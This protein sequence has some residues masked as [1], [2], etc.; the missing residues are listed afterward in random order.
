MLN[1]NNNNN[2]DSSTNLEST[3]FKTNDET[4]YKT[5]NNEKMS[6]IQK[7]LKRA[8]NETRK[9]WI[10]ILSTADESSSSSIESIYEK[11]LEQQISFKSLDSSSLSKYNQ[12]NDVSSSS[13]TADNSLSTKN[14]A[15]R[16]V[17]QIEKKASITE[18][19][20]D[21]APA[22]INLLTN[23]SSNLRLQVLNESNESKI[24]DKSLKIHSLATQAIKKEILTVRNFDKDLTL[25]KNNSLNS[26]SDSCSQKSLKNE[27]KQFLNDLFVSNFLIFNRFYF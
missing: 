27:Q 21:V 7:T 1:V 23:E 20:L 3:T 18:N 6:L 5:I 10:D 19:R 17:G 14:K 11:A 24:M 15:N 25:H 13:S 2:N 16:K 9:K 4:T 8:N 12:L 22:K 26:S